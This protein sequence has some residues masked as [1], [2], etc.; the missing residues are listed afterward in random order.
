MQSPEQNPDNQ[1]RLFKN[2][3]KKNER[4]PDYKGQAK[5]GQAEFYLA[6]WINVA[7]T[8]G[9]KY[10]KLSF[11]AKNEEKSVSTGSAANVTDEIPF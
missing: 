6:A 7:K 2:D 5:V 3:Q 10:M 4:D 8:S 9:Q 11:T 1:G